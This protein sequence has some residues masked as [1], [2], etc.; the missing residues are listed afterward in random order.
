MTK[1]LV[2]AGV[3]CA[4]M[5][6]RLEVRNHCALP[7]GPVLFVANHGFGGIVDLNLLTVAA[8]Y[9]ELGDDRDIVTLTHAMAWKLGIGRVVEEFDA[10]P[11]GHDTAMK[12]FA[13]N[14]HVL[15]FP[16]GDIDAMKPWSDRNKVLFAGRS[17]FARLAMEA[18][19]PVVPV[20]TA[21]A[22]ESLYVLSNGKRLAEM[23]GATKLLRL[24]SLPVS[25]SLPWGFSV[26]LAG[27]LP[28]VPLPTKLV[29]TILPTMVPNEDETPEAFADRVHTAMQDEMTGMTSG[30][31]PVIG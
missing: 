27:L 24:H 23:I 8:A 12:A 16:G 14:K 30:R 4:R 15:V 2:D 18:G 17:G 9:D 28:Y 31:R 10:R 5:Y 26:G 25:V 3:A 7:T 22:G 6:N 11:A 20:V 13:E 21:G 19:V 1:M 29:T